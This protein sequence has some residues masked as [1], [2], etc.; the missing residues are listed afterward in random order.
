MRTSKLSSYLSVLALAGAVGCAGGEGVSSNHDKPS[1][2]TWT[3]TLYQEPSTGRYIVDWDMAVSADELPAYY[4]R[5][6]GSGELTVNQVNGVD[7]VWNA[8]AKHQLTYCIGN[9]GANQ[10]RVIDAMN[11]ATAGWQASADITFTH[12]SAQDGAAC[13]ASNPNVLFDVNVTSGGQ[14]IARAFFPSSPRAQR[15]VLID[16]TAFDID[17]DDVFSL[18]GVLAHE[19]GHALGFRHEHVRAPIF[20]IPFEN[21]L[22]CI[23]EGFLD[24]NYRP[25]TNYDSA[26]VMHYPQC[27]GTGVLQITALDVQGAQAIY[28]APN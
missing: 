12:V 27:G 19:L 22:N 15:N 21:W 20:N 2:E 1:F 11:E 14:F 24:Q 18:D 7:D 5:L 10:Q 28:G 17:E 23:L 3:E 25:V 4:D 9:F 13:T 6:Y 8:T 16:T 26:S